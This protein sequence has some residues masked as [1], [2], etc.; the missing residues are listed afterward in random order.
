MKTIRGCLSILCISLLITHYM[1]QN[2]QLTCFKQ[3]LYNRINDGRIED[4]NSY[5]ENIK[6][7][8]F[9]LKSFDSFKS[10]YVLSSPDSIRGKDLL[11]LLR[12]IENTSQSGTTDLV[13][14]INSLP[15]WNKN[16]TNIAI[17]ILRLMLYSDNNQA[18]H[19]HIESYG[20]YSIMAKANCL[21]G[22]KCPYW[23]HCNNNFIDEICNGNINRFALSFAPNNSASD[24]KIKA[25]S[26]LWHHFS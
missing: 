18:Q 15:K 8:I 14:M 7:Y 19:S 12:F 5:G 22:E 11:E 26:A 21:M 2:I 9:Q 17:I 1:T 23:H 25:H 10:E 3:K 4:W 20:D 16:H 13:Q 24:P 6:S